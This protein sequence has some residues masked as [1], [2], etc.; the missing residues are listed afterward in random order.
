[1][2]ALKKALIDSHVGSYRKSERAVERVDICDMPVIRCLGADH[3][4]VGGE[5]FAVVHVGHTLTSV[6]V[7]EDVISHNL[8]RLLCMGPG[9]V[10][11]CGGSCALT[12]LVS[13]RQCAS[14]PANG[15]V[16]G[17]AGGPDTLLPHLGLLL[18]SGVPM[19]KTL[20]LVSA[21]RETGFS[22]NPLRRPPPLWP[23]GCSESLRGCPVFTQMALSTIAS[24]EEAGVLPQ[25]LNKVA[26]FY[27]LQ[28]EQALKS[29]TGILEPII[30][31]GVEP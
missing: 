10:A 4:A 28:V 27:E 16:A 3:P 5:F 1:M 30:M 7:L 18:D 21:L 22:R 24:G 11:T 17:T 19:V 26:E 8:A 20:Q 6:T 29:L 23:R 15:G 12:R 14:A 13:H 9:W 25:M 2:V 31:M